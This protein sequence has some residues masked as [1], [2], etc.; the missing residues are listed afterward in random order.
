MAVFIVLVYAP[1]YASAFQIED[2]FYMKDISGHWAEDDLKQLVY[3]GILKGDNEQKSNPDN[4]ITR[5]EFIVLMVRGLNYEDEVESSVFKDVN[6]G[7]WFYNDVM[8]ARQRGI[9]IGD[10]NGFFHPYESITREEIVLMLVRALE[11]DLQTASANK[12]FSDIS[13]SYQYLKELN[14]AVSSGII[15]GYDDNTFRPRN[16]ASRAEAA[17]MIKRMMSVDGKSLDDVKEQSIIIDFIKQYMDEYIKSKNKGLSDIRFNL[18]RSVGRENDYNRAK[19]EIIDLYHQTGIHVTQE[20]S[21]REID[22]TDINS[23]FAEV[24]VVSDVSY[25]RAFDDMT[26]KVN[27]YKMETKFNLRKIDGQWMVYNA[28]ERLY[29]DDKISLTWEQISVKTPDMSGVQKME[30]LDVISPTWFELRANTSSMGVKASDPVVYSDEQGSIH[31]IDMGD[32][33]FIQ[34]AQNNAYDVWALFRNESDINVANKVLNSKEARK[35]SLELLLQYTDKYRLD[36]INI[37][38]E[39]MYYEDRHAFSQ[40]VRE[41]ALLMREQGVVTSVDVTKIEPTSLTWS[42]CYDREALGEAVDYLIL[43]AYDQ[44]GTWSQKSGSVAQLSWVEGALKEVMQQVSN[45][46]ILLGIPFYTRVWEETNGKVTKTMAISMETAN[47]LIQDNNASMVW[48]E[49]SGQYIATYYKDGKTYKIWVEDA[50][51]IHLKTQLV[52]KYNLAGVAGW[53]RGFET[54]DIW[55][56][57]AENLK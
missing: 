10:G 20:I 11:T 45:E 6:S 56:V 38:F 7:D 17:V 8:I 36:G 1:A 31:M 15:T 46:K 25:T 13:K 55:G 39:N 30:G 40:Y 48:D 24:H 28:E 21:N 51:S 3:M 54:Q 22:V 47:N 35:S 16:N 44:N 14:M 50:T 52:K 43:M 53:R 34:W 23:N 41:I 5:A 4:L 27:N 29:T 18:A 32:E 33:R 42:M 2:R 49:K 57:I 19:A 37:D 26:Q 9:T 12:S